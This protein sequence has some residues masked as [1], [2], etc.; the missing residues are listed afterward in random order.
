M[1][2]AFSRIGVEL[3]DGG[4]IVNLTDANPKFPASMVS[5]LK[6]GE[7]LLYEAKRLVALRFAFSVDLILSEFSFVQISGD[8]VKHFT[9]MF[10]EA[11]VTNFEAREGTLFLSYFYCRQQ[12]IENI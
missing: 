12:P 4:D 11:T 6:G 5:F 8:G 9:E 10:S 7:N 3:K 2:I 1:F